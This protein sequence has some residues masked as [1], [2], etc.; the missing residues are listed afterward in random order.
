MH[1]LVVKWSDLDANG[2]TRNTA[3]MEFAIQARMG[4][5]YQGGFGPKQF[6]EHHVG[7]VIFSDFTRYFKE[8]HAFDELRINFKQAGVST[9]GVRFIIQNEIFNRN[10]ELIALVRSEGAWFDLQTRRLTVPPDA[11]LKLAR[12]LP[13]TDDFVEIQ[14]KSN[15]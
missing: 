3:Y 13:H 2:H 10:D 1:T 5:Y 6:L 8:T 14:R 12:A 15:Q 11:L 9:D 4:Y 7:P